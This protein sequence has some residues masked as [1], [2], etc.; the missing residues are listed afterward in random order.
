MSTEFLESLFD[1]CSDAPIIQN[2]PN[3]P[4]PAPSPSPPAAPI[5]NNDADGVAW[6]TAGLIYVILIALVALGWQVAL[7]RP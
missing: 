7:F 5:S 2:A 6:L 3:P 1:W 4:P